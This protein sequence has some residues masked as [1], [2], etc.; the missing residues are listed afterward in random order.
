MKITIITL[1]FLT[2]WLHAG[3]PSVEVQNAWLRA[4]PPGSPATAGYLTLINRGSTDLTLTGATSNI[5]GEVKPMITT[6]TKVNGQEVHGME[7]VKFL[8]IPAG[9]RLELKP[10][11]DHLM[12]LQLSRVPQAKE[13]VP[14]TLKFGADEL[15][16]EIPVRR[17]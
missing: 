10:G 16:L 9:G 4:V 5:A 1:F 8:M 17:K 11:G 15:S 7:F 14:V 2:G 12:F 6:T 13:I 3:V